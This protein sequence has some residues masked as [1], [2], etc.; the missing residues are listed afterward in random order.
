MSKYHLTH[1][2]KRKNSRTKGGGGLG[3]PRP[4]PKSALVHYLCIATNQL[5]CCANLP[6]TNTFNVHPYI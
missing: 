1:V 3:S 5:L 6:V 2:Y 4:T